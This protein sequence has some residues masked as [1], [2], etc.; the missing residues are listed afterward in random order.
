MPAENRHLIITLITRILGWMV[1]EMK[2]QPNFSAMNVVKSPCSGSSPADGLRVFA[3]T[4]RTSVITLPIT[5]VF[6]IG[7]LEAQGNEYVGALMVDAN[8][9]LRR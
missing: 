5:R 8:T 1:C 9:A 4:Y 7:S 3:Y 6:A 2:S